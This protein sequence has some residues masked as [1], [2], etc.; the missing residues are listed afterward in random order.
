VKLPSPVK[1]VTYS[2]ETQVVIE[3][4]ANDLIIQEG[5]S[6]GFVEA[7]GFQRFLQVTATTRKPVS[8]Q[9]VAEKIVDKSHALRST[10]TQK[11]SLCCSINATVAVS[12]DKQL[13][14]SV[15]VTVHY[16]EEANGL[17]LKAYSLPSAPIVGKQ[18]DDK[19]KFALNSLMDEFHMN[20]ILDCVLVDSVV[21]RRNANATTFPDDALLSL[22][23]SIEGDGQLAVGVE[24]L[25]DDD[26][27]WKSSED[28]EN[29][30][31]SE[32]T[33][34]FPGKHQLACFSHSLQCVVND[35]IKQSEGKSTCTIFLKS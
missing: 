5:L 22:P 17:F 18:T 35:G 1:P 20:S 8:M 6:I 9:S 7:V 12:S 25:F 11:L 3:S 2:P 31:L 23:V 24:V 10:I 32:N 15:N 33:Q 27:V 13:G 26:S 4:I 34:G 16:M 21:N 19:I 28:N 30:N 14:E 29:H